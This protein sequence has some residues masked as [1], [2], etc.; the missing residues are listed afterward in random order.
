MKLTEVLD[1]LLL[2][3]K[4]GQ[5]NPDII[6]V[7]MDSRKVVEGSLFVCMEGYTVDGHDFAPQAVGKGAAAVISERDMDLPVPVIIVKDTH[8]ALAE[9]AGVFYD[10]PTKAFRLIGVTGTNGK[11]TVTHLIEKVFKDQL[12]LTGLIGTI[13]MKIGDEVFETKNTTPESLLLQQQFAKM[14]DAKVDT[15]VMEVS[16]HALSLGRTRGCDFDVAVF[17]NLTQDHLDYHQTMDDYRHAKELLF[18]QLGN[19]YD[20]NRRKV[21]VLNIDDPA[22]KHYE[23]ATAAHVL[24]YGIEGDADLKAENITFTADGTRFDL[25]TPDKKVPVNLQLVGKFSVYN[26]LAAV[27]ACM[28][29]GI[30]LDDILASLKKVE[31]VP[32]R[33]ELVNEG[34]DFPVIVDYAHTPDSLENVLK[35]IKEFADGEIYS[36]TGCGGDR[37]RTKRPLMANIATKY[38]D[39]AIFTSDNPRSEDP[40]QILEDME[41]GA[42]GPYTKIEERREAIRYAV[43]QAQSGDVILIA[44]KGHETYQIIGSNVYDFDDRQVAREAIR[45]R[46]K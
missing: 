19:T 35:T 38:S 17:T 42:K 4:V 34:Q 1:G 37:D 31:G 15:A 36:I 23:K 7:E 45:E 9:I 40:S 13:N 20:R 10:N 43:N 29:S 25:V 14:R 6:H 27:G 39:Y 22:S 12:L 26:A 5:G 32:G 11:T 18:S 30:A 28:V 16:S 21:A 2:Y 41:A 46:L 3:K 33:F 8:R 24:T 44:G